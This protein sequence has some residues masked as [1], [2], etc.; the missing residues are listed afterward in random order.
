MR[1]NKYYELYTKE[2][3][4]DYHTMVAVNC[5]SAYLVTCDTRMSKVCK[6]MNPEMWRKCPK[7]TGIVYK[8][9]E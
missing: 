5:S 1:R 9:K 2:E 4:P 3:I 6:R 8:H 7:Q